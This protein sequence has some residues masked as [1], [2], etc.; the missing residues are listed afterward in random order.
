[1]D[2]SVIDQ[3]RQVMSE[4]ARCLQPS[5]AEG[6]GASRSVSIAEFTND[7]KEHVSGQPVTDEGK[8][9]IQYREHKYNLNVP[10]N[11]LMEVFKV[12]IDDVATSDGKYMAPVSFK[13]Q[14]MHL[15]KAIPGFVQ[16]VRELLGFVKALDLQFMD[17]N[18]TE[19]EDHYFTCMRL[20]DVRDFLD[21]IEKS[22]ARQEIAKVAAAEK[23][24]PAGQ[25]QDYRP[26]E[27]HGPG[28][29]TFGKDK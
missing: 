16:Q 14:A 22:T 11:E 13:E 23:P 12:L 1:M 29:G 27:R 17:L 21:T 3:A 10:V 5:I 18:Y 6:S 15:F 28:K 24:K 26:A 4:R 2:Q 25:M 19:K 9:I 8:V 7:F 20:Q